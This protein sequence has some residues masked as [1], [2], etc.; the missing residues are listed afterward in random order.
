[1]SP[2]GCRPAPGWRR[3]SPFLGDPPG[4]IVMTVF[5][6]LV[7]TT[8]VRLAVQRASAGIEFAQSY[9]RGLVRSCGERLARF[10]S[11]RARA[12]VPPPVHVSKWNRWGNGRR[13]SKTAPGRAS[14]RGRSPDRRPVVS[15]G[16]LDSRNP[17]R[18]STL[19]GRALVWWNPGQP[20][21]IGDAP[22]PA[23]RPGSWLRRV[24]SSFRDVVASGGFSACT[25]WLG[26]TLSTRRAESWATP[27]SSLLTNLLTT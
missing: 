20:E 26:F 14:P 17:W 11:P 10:T 8:S 12:P 1:M 21:G 27:T 5:R 24:H 16:K 6:L 2:R 13:D 22:H 3:T 7:P 25:S 9:L 15:G 18:A 4:R 19:Y 23:P